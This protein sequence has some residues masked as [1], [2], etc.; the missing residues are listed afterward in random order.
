MGIK[1]LISKI[2]PE[3]LKVESTFEVLRGKTMGVD[4]SNYLFKLVTS[5]DNLVRDFHSEP[6]IDTSGQIKKFWDSF[7]KVC[8]GFDIK[9]VLVLDGRRNVAKF[10]TNQLRESRRADA[11]QKLNDLLLNGDID[12]SEKV[13]K[14]QKS[15]MYISEDM[16]HSVK[17]W[18]ASNGVICVQSLYEADAGLQH[19]EDMGLT[20]GTFSEDGD[21]FPLN[22][23][24]WATKV[25]VTKGT[26]TLFNSETV[27]EA[28]AVRLLTS[29]VAIMTADHGRV[30]SVLLGSDFLPRPAGFG[31]KTVEKF[32]STWM[33]SSV[34]ENERSL[35]EIEIGKKKRK[36]R[37]SEVVCTDG[38][39]N[40]SIKFWQAFNM[41]KHPPVFK[42][43]SLA[44]DAVVSVG[45]LGIDDTTLS[46]EYVFRTLGFNALMDVSNLGDYNK[47]LFI[48]DNIFVRTM[49]PLLPII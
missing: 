28:L 49:L 38:F 35:L 26:L 37:D 45:L 43:T 8:D 12:D 11:I 18:S 44:G 31:P 39:P 23:K 25:S 10:D 40:Y 3:E 17:M 33:I 13:L 29:E 15:T 41:L 30:L 9:L 21:F 7:K 46:D 47:L 22:S 27:R 2:F 19:L 5:R 34:E 48:E 6:R 1:D 16:L 4:V 42:F 24:L 36:N 32:L 14:L 20:D